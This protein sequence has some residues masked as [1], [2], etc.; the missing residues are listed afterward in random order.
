[1]AIG[2]CIRIG[3][4]VLH[5][6]ENFEGIVVLVDGS[7]FLPEIVVRLEAGG[8]IRRKMGDFEKVAGFGSVA[9]R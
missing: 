2:D 6:I 1:M 7:G 9:V 3:D 5:L 8:T 4:R